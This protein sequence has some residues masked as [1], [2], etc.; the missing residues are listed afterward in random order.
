MAIE[1][2]KYERDDFGPEAP[3]R[4]EITDKINEIIDYINSKEEYTTPLCKQCWRFHRVWEPY[5]TIPMDDEQEP[6]KVE[7]VPLDVEEI[8]DCMTN[9][10]LTK[11]AVRAILSKY[12][13]PTQQPVIDWENPI[14]SIDHWKG[15]EDQ[16]C[17][18]VSVKDDKGKTYVIDIC[19]YSELAEKQFF[20]PDYVND[21]VEDNSERIQPLWEKS[22]IK[23]FL[24][25]NW[26]IEE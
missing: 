6:N 8:L 25:D 2:L 13:V 5:D 9:A 11:D 15:I 10:H 23:M 21:R 1:N 17:R 16:T 24:R 19:Q 3:S 26:L 4:M 22:I 7:L 20:T 14:V 12:W 18:V